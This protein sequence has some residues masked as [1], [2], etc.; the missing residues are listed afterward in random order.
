MVDELSLNMEKEASCSNDFSRDLC[1]SVVG[2]V[3]RNWI[4]KV[5]LFEKCLSMWHIATAQKQ[6]WQNVYNDCTHIHCSI[7]LNSQKVGINIG[8]FMNE[9]KQNVIY[10]Y[11][12]MFFSLKKKR[13]PDT[14]T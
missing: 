6:I 11:H 4:Y 10:T 13:N 12:E 7:I 8:P 3:G 2:R 5:T 14:A 9:I 1:H